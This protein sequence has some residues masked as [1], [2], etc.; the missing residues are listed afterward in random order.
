MK[1]NAKKDLTRWNRAGLNQFRYIDGNAISYLETLRLELLEQFNATPHHQWSELTT[2]LPEL[3]DEDMQQRNQRLSSQYYDERRDYAWEIL[4][5]FSRSAHILGEYINAYANEAYLPTA[6][7]WD[8]V[9]KLVAM[10]DYR[11]SPPASAATYIALLLKKGQSGIIETGFSVKN[12]PGRGE[13][14]LIF[15]T[16]QNL[17]GSASINLL[18]LHQWNS[19][20]AV[21]QTSAGTIYFPLE[22]DIKGLHKGMTGVLTNSS[23]GIPVSVLD[24]QQDTELDTVLTLKFLNS[25]RPDNRFY[26]Y[27][28]RLYLDPKFV[29]SPH[30]RGLNSI[31]TDD[32]ILASNDNIIFKYNGEW[33]AHRITASEHNKFL[34]SG[35]FPGVSAGDS[36]YQAFPLHRQKHNK[37][38]SGSDIFILPESFNEGHNFFVD[39]A[40]KTVSKSYA[41]KVID[42]DGNIQLS[43]TPG[44]ALRYVK[45]NNF[46]DIIYMPG[47]PF[48]AKVEHATLTDLS[49]SARKTALREDQWVLIK[50][51]NGALRG[52]Q[53]TGIDQQKDQFSLSLNESTDNIQQLSADFSIFARL[54]QHDR[55]LNPAWST[56]SSAAVTLMDIEPGEALT[57]ITIGQKLIVSSETISHVVTLQEIVP[58][59]DKI[60]LH[61]S[62]PFHQDSRST[63]MTRSNTVIYGNV[64]LAT[65][66]ETQ[67]EKIIGNGD[68]SLS[69]QIFQLPSNNIAWIADSAFNAGVRAD[70]TVRVG[71]RIWKQV[72]DLSLSAAEDQHYSVTCLLYTSPSPRD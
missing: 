46:G 58:S 22:A 36:L 2:R 62:P 38:E 13:S 5:S 61:L 50:A 1:L 34:L 27:N 48:S 47:L 20:D 8:N 66:G 18:H 12:K 31:Q 72:A 51:A 26:Y 43:S 57:A 63:T 3:P 4:R 11:P 21:F 14:T 30:P 71:Q 60:T 44:T 52:A 59:S 65:H 10:L 15:E 69:N 70:L 54:K 55:N 25:E 28:T 23:K 39:K 56:A 29:E 24:I 33:S 37:I 7:E 42:K 41:D 35:T 64:I 9:R 19:N 17:Q 68:A 40:L 32:E 6:T 16:R 45:D 49:F 67:P 53:I